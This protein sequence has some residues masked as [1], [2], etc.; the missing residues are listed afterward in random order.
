[1]KFE[2][3]SSVYR[4]EICWLGTLHHRFNTIV[5]GANA[6]HLEESLLL[7]SGQIWQENLLRA[8]YA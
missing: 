8:K 1:M 5:K 4:S 7:C 3:S 6:A 2:V